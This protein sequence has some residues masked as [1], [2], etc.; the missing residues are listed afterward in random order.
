[1]DLYCHGCSAKGQEATV[2]LQHKKSQLDRMEE[3]VTMEGVQHGKT[4]PE[5]LQNLH[6]QIFKTQQGLQKPKVAM[7]QALL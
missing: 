3:F 5:R 6:P 7:E 2:R 1:M 4:G